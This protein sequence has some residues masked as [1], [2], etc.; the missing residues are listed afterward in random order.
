MK[1][2]D[3]VQTVLDATYDEVP[4]TEAVRDASI[5]N[6]L[7]VMADQYRNKLMTH[8]GPDFDDPATRFGYVYQHV[9][10]HAHWMYDLIQ[11]SPQ[12]LAVLKSGKARITCIGGG[13]GSDVV[14]ILKVLDETEESCSLFCELIDGCEAW[15]STWSDL[16]F[17]LDL[18]G[19]LHTDYVIHDVSDKSTWSSPSRIGKADIITLSFFVSE[20]HHLA[21]SVEYL[22]KMLQ[23]AKSGAVLLVLDNRTPV[24]YDAIDG[25][26]ASAGFK[27]LKSDEETWKIYDAGEQM[28][29]LQKYSMKFARS[30]KLTG[31]VSWRTFQKK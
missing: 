22:T 29:R 6:A 14:G 15:K 30:S 31:E 1:C 19:A 24:I 2:F 27:K 3:V 21:N 28:S 16:A 18:K 17:Q 7:T 8:G 9:P 11:K 4:G 5:K 25:I 26:A 12:A 23:S 13:P 20:I 10:A